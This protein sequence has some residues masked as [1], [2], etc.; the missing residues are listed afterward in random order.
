MPISKDKTMISQQYLELINVFPLRPL[1]NDTDLNEAVV[2]CDRLIDRV[3]LT[4]AEFDYLHVIE[5]L[6]EEYEEKTLVAKE[7]SGNEIITFLME[8]NNLTQ[9]QLCKETGLAKTT[10]SEV[11]S[12]KRGISRNVATLLAR[13]FRVRA[14]LFLT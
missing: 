8:E 12:K 14:S 2:I 1:Q 6:I 11:L 13:R 10:L 4:D 9:T 3:E 5:L 7:F